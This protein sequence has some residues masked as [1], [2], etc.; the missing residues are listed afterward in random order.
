MIASNVKIASTIIGNRGNLEKGK[1]QMI[2]KIKIGMTIAI[3]GT[4]ISSPVM[5]AT[6]SFGSFATTTDNPVIDTAP[7]VTVNDDTAGFLTF[8]ITTP[9]ANGQLSGIFID[10]AGDPSYSAT[11]ITSLITGTDIVD[12]AQDTNNIGNGRNLNGNFGAPIG[13]P[14]GTFDIAFGFDDGENGGNGRQIILPF[15]F[16]L[17]DLGTLTLSSITRIGL[18]FQSVGD[19]GL[20]GLGDGSE[21]LISFSTPTPVP[22]PAAGWLLLSGLAG[23]R[24]LRR[25]KA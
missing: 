20:D 8:S 24:I 19:L 9:N 6:I 2:Q 11:D 10:L 22:L 4:F 1:Y 21:K 25:R 13:G 12:F 7:L 5:S 17:A 3:L 15:T 23:I 18:R 14:S 16:T